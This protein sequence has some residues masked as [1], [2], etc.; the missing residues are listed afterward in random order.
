[1]TFP[2]SPATHPETVYIEYTEDVPPGFSGDKYDIITDC[3]ERIKALHD[4]KRK[5]FDEGQNGA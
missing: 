5:E 2:Y 4:R 1:M 3:P